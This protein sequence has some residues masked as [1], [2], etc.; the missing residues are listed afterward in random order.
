MTSSQT[1]QVVVM[2]DTTPYVRVHKL[3]SGGDPVV[4]HTG[5]CLTGWVEFEMSLLYARKIEGIKKPYH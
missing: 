2:F 4:V 1:S 3:V 5:G